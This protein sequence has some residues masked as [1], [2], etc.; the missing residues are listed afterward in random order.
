MG[1]FR[2]GLATITRPVN[3]ND[4]FFEGQISRF[5]IYSHSMTVSA[6]RV[7]APSAVACMFALDTP[8]VGSN[9]T[10]FPLSLDL[11][12]VRRLMRKRTCAEG[13]PRWTVSGSWVAS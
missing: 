12:F 10:L 13:K 5:Q 7:H 4:A 2:R 8:P 3:T 9:H 11:P 6:V 1:F